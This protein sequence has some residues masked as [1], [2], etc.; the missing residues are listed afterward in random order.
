MLAKALLLLLPVLKRLEK[1]EA[2]RKT[3][4]EKTVAEQRTD[5]EEKTEV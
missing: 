1:T 4:A 5:A 2:E 3:E